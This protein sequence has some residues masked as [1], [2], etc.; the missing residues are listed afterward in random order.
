MIVHSL[1]TSIMNLKPSSSIR[2]YMPIIVALTQTMGCEPI[3]SDDVG[4]F[5]PPST[6]LG[7]DADLILSGMEPGATTFSLY[8]FFADGTN[9]KLLDPGPVAHY[10][11]SANRA[12]IVVNRDEYD[13]GFRTLHF[14][15]PDGGNPASVIFPDD[16]PPDAYFVFSISPTGR[17]VAYGSLTNYVYGAIHVAP[18]DGSAPELVLPDGANNAWSWSPTEDKLAVA[19]AGSL[20]IYDADTKGLVE[21]TSPGLE[22]AGHT[23]WASWSPNGERLAFTEGVFQNYVLT[24]VD[25]L[26]QDRRELLTNLTQP[27]S[28]RSSWSPNS[29]YFALRPVSHNDFSQTD[30]LWLVDADG[31][32]SRKFTGNPFIGLYGWSPGLSQTC[33]MVYHPIDLDIKSA[34]IFGEDVTLVPKD[35]TFSIN[36]IYY[37][38]NGRFAYSSGLELSTIHADGSTPVTYSPASKWRLSKDGTVIVFA[39]YPD[40]NGSMPVYAAAADDPQTA[41]ILTANTATGISFDAIENSSGILFQATNGPAG[42]I[43]PT[44]NGFQAIYPQLPLAKLGARAYAIEP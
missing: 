14:V 7:S 44:N 23:Q 6:Q 1:Y 32:K 15:D 39:L 33:R 18:T 19:G 11:L 4:C 5:P 20:F 36:Q 3:E 17:Y 26:G 30:Y 37:G 13:A 9:A 31:T 42:W 28:L 22:I 29:R 34:T 40:A 10:E 27:M 16:A 38:P 35:K 25:K 41:L 43:L 24:S 8:R 21:V 12:R 2:S